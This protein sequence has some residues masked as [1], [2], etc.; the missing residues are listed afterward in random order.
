MTKRAFDKIASGLKD[1]VAITKGKADRK[2]YRVHIPPSIDVKAIRKTTG[3][4]QD[5]FARQFGINAARLRDLEQGR[6]NPDSALRAYL[7]VIA[8][9]PDVVREALRADAA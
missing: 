1:A 7:L 4:T 2:T 9:K 5:E 8:K 6:S 3:L